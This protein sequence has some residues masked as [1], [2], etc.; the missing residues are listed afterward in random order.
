MTKFFIGESGS[1]VF[2]WLWAGHRAKVYVCVPCSQKLEVRMNRLRILVCLMILTGFVFAQ[3]LGKDSLQID[4][5]KR[6]KLFYSS[7]NNWIPPSVLD[8]PDT[9]TIKATSSQEKNGRV[10]IGIRGGIAMVLVPDWWLNIQS[11]ITTSLNLR[12]VCWHKFTLEGELTN[13]WNTQDW[14]EL[15]PHIWSLNV[16]ENKKKIINPRLGIDYYYGYESRFGWN[17]GMYFT[18][19]AAK[20]FCY[21]ILLLIRFEDIYGSSGFNIPTEPRGIYGSIGLFYVK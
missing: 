14:W 19:P 9:S 17:L 1:C 21:D 8:N 11:P 12:I 3:G 13:I 10:G 5:L 2:L 16:Y 6:Q 15:N 18:T 4:L 20:K 7:N